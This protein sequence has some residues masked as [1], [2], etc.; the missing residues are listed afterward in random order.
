[1]SSKNRSSWIF[2]LAVPVC[3]GFALCNPCADA[4]TTDTQ[5]AVAARGD[6]NGIVTPAPAV[7]DRATSAADAT[8]GTDPSGKGCFRAAVGAEVPEPR[9]LRSVN[10]ILK[11]DLSFRSFVDSKGEV[12]YCYVTLNGEQAPT[13]RVKPGDTVILNFKNE[14]TAAPQPSRTVAAN[15][16][17]GAATA[18][19][20]GASPAPTKNSAKEM[21]GADGATTENRTMGGGTTPACANGAM[22]ATSTNLHFHGLT[23]PPTC[24]QDD[25]MHTMIA[26]GSAPYEYKFQI[27]ADEPPGLYW[28]HPHIHGFTKAQVLGGASAALVVEGIERAIPDLAGLHERVL[29]VRDQNLA[30]PDAAPVDDAKLP[31][32]VLDADGD[33]MNTGTGTGKPAEDLTLNYVPV[34]Y[35]NYPP[36]TITM[37]P[38]ER[39]LWRVLNASAI[40]YL[41]LQVL[42]GPQVQAVEVVA[43]DGVPIHPKSAG[44]NHYILLT[45]LG[46][47]PGGRIE[48]VLKGP[49]EGVMASLVT[50]SVNTGAMGENDPTRAIANI[51]A[52]ADAPEPQSSLAKN[53]VPLPTSATTWLRDVTPVRVRRLFFSETPLDPKDPNSPPTFY[54]TVDG[55][56]PKAF[57]PSSDLPNIVTHQGDV[58]DWILENRS[59]EL[60]AFHIHQTH[61]ALMEFFGLTVNEPFLRDTV[62]VPYWDG[63]NPVYP[64]VRLRMDFRD[65]NAVGTYPFHCHLLEHEDSGMMGLIRVEAAK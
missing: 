27:P 29:I 54:L 38:G 5:N 18:T 8:A 49:A 47:P 59:Q 33:V 43:L 32:V 17:L 14:A 46:V 22:K 26:T 2:K 56:T 55:E 65:P 37:K 63:K 51:V 4:Q 12:R 3:L 11:V 57:D 15:G 31:P 24:H 23:V 19:P 61:F 53:P 35:P 34:P 1:M 44:L 13:L 40:T 6:S 10:G 62:N 25:V 21:N 20:G 41:S 30:N 28:Y 39:Q 64:R 50:R 7:T 45:H 16:Q 9:D 48:F 36:A 58:E 52:K 60:H 42:F